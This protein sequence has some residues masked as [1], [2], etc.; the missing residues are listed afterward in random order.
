[1]SKHT[2]Q[3]YSTISQAYEK[4]Y[5]EGYGLEYPDGHVIRFYQRV[6]KYEFN[7]SKGNILDFG[8][9]TGTHLKFFQRHGF[10]PF[11]VDIIAEAIEKTKLLLPE[12]KDNFHV[13]PYM[14]NLK[15]YFSESFDI[16]FS[17]QT[18][19]YFND[20]D[21][22]NICGQ[23]LDLLKPGGIFFATMV[24]PLSGYYKIVESTSGDMSK[25]VLNGR[26]NETTFLNFKTSEEVLDVFKDFKRTHFGS[27]DF[28]LTEDPVSIDI[29]YG[30]GHHYMFVGRKE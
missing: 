16:I 3:D 25:V 5:D 12:F 15:D 11:G 17:N 29:S 2:E 23:F 27:Y 7:I 20:R 22:K 26:L 18:L 4:K 13:T 24:S 8:C 1:M 6:L 9:G 19:Y 10:T 28:V 14:P 21:I 30:R